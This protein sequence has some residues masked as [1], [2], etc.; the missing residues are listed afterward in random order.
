MNDRFSTFRLFVRV[1]RTG[2]FSA[3]GR[4]LGL[5]QPSVSRIIAALEQEVGVALLTRSTRAVTLTEAGNDYLARIEP[6]LTALEEADHAVRGTGELRGLLRVS[7]VT[8]FAVREIIPRL[9]RFTARHPRL[10]IE[11]VLNDQRQ[12]LVSEGIDVALRF[13]ALTDSGLTAR[14]IC[15]SRRLMAASPAYLATAGTPKVPEDLAAHPMILG[16][17]GSVQEGW[18]FRKDGKTTTIRIEG[19]L[20]INSAEGTTAAA[21]AGLGIVSTGYMACRAELASGTLV[22][23]LPDWQMAT[24]GVHALT[25]S[26]RAAKPSA[27]AF[28]DFLNSPATDNFRM[29]R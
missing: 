6:I 2:S 1:A 3:A 11:F 23:V 29:K 25:P 28:T 4:E 18:T 15:V 27:R 7:T 26:G 8:S 17:A 13:G 19:Q 9:P 5:S 24:A 10:R 12:D 20:V 14:R 16:P 21:I 22:E